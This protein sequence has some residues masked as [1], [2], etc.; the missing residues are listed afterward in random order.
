MRRIVC[1][2]TDESDFLRQIRWHQGATGTDQAADF[3][4]VG[5]FALNPGERVRL[6]ALVSRAR[7]Q[8]HLDVTILDVLPVAVDG[9]SGTTV[10]RY[11]ARVAAEDAV[12][13]LAFR[14][15]MSARRWLEEIAA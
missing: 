6:T 12:W 2:F 5:D 11:R 4:F 1:R 8:C 10:F 14:Q 3:M 13:L 15:R 7:E 9:D